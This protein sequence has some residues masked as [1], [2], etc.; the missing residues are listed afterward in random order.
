MII[1]KCLVVILNF[2]FDKLDQLQ[3]SM[4]HIKGMVEFS[5][6]LLEDEEFIH[7]KCMCNGY[8]GLI[9]FLADSKELRD[10]IF[11][12]GKQ[13]IRKKQVSGL[14]KW[15]EVN[16]QGEMIKKKKETYVNCCRALKYSDDN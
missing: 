13:P 2:N 12:R 1:D 5:D 7:L 9:G 10:V 3:G 15:W 6:G 8:F 14:V 11:M 4:Q 16:R